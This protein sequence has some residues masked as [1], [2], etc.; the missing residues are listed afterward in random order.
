MN[1]AHEL[2]TLV[3][4]LIDLRERSRTGALA[5]LTRTRGSTFRRVGTSMLVHDDGGIV[6]ELS[7]GCPQRDI[8]ERARDA[9]RDGTPR[10]VRYN[11]A[12]GLDLMIEMGCGGELD[13]LIE[14]LVG[15]RCLDFVDALDEGIRRRRPGRLVTLFA[16]NGQAVPP[17]RQVWFGGERHYD[18]IGDPVLDEALAATVSDHDARSSTFSLQTSRGTAEVLVELVAPLHRL[19]VIGSS[20]AAHAMLP[21]ATALGWPVTLVDSNP[22]RLRLPTL[23]G[24]VH[25]VC[26]SPDALTRHYPFDAYTSVVVMTHNLE[27][28]MAYIHALRDTPLTYVGVIGSRDRVRRMHEGE[29]LSGRTVHAPAGL[30]IGSETPTEIALAIAAEIVATIHDRS[31]GPLRDRDG[32]IH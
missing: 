10:I 1:S 24:E 31:G 19:V 17:R 16:Q 27:Q 2:R 3:D 26:A 4:A 25:T 11:A 22:D 23:P 18:G 6:C 12:N 7:G 13:I 15:P 32:A 30:D 5:T 28:D 14:P 20:A 29:R 9:M 21:L 8:V